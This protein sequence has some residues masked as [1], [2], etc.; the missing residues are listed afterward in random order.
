M[1]KVKTF[2]TGG[3]GFIGSHLINYLINKKNTEIFALIRNLNKLK[4]L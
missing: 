4:W 2:I 3:T 1:Q